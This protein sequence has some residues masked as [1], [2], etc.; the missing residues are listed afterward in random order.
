MRFST[1]QHPLYCGS[2]LPVCTMD[3]YVLHQEGALLL[4]R[5]RPAG[6]ETF[7]KA[8]APSRDD[9]VVAVAC[10][11]PWHGLAALCAQAGLP[12][13]LGPALSMQVLHGGKATH[14]KLDAPQRAAWWRGA[15]RPPA[16][17]APAA[18]RAPRA[19]W[20]RRWPLTRQRAAWLRSVQQT[21]RQENLP[22]IGIQMAS[23]AHRAVVGERAP[24]PAVQQSVDVSLAFLASYARLRSDIALTILPTAKPHAAQSLY[25]LQTVPG[26]SNMVR[27]VWLDER[28][29]LTRIPRVQDCVASC[30]LGKC[31][32]ASAG[33]RSGTS[34]ATMGQA[35]L[36][37]YVS[38][39]QRMTST[40]LCTR[41]HPGDS[42]SIR[43]WCRHR[44]PY[45]DRA[46][47][48]EH[49]A[50]E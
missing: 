26:M 5:H 44:G 4:H 9:M 42:A 34:G 3:L 50:R 24:A 14:A 45:L 33:K 40:L 6:P 11:F 13:G 7:R 8:I 29:D 30:R 31:D 46:T 23:K 43:V 49:S 19:L 27:V 22:E 18:L 28:P 36:N 15:K 38:R 10:L 37:G 21:H 41:H 35:S 1:Q 20:R 16:D 2:A 48:T 12:C 25:R 39:P 47:K 17:V 32:Q